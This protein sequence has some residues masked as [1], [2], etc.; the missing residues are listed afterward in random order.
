MKNWSEKIPHKDGWPDI[1]TNRCVLTGNVAKVKVLHRLYRLISDG[2]TPSILDIGCVGPQPLEFW[3]PLLAGNEFSF[4]LTGVDIDGI[5]TAQNIVAQR[6]WTDRVTLRQG[7]GYCLSDLFEPRS[8]NVVIATQVLEHLAQLSLCMQQVAT[9]LT[10]AGEGFFTT[11][12]AHWRS[13]FDLRE[14]VRLVKNVTKKGLGVFGN[15][16]H[17]DLPWFDYEVAAACKQAGLG[18]IE[19]RYYNLSPLKFIHNH[20]VPPER[21][22][23]FMR[24]WF[25]LEEFLNEEAVARE[26]LRHFFLVLYLH[27]RK[28]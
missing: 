2:S 4:H 11:D 17:Y 19:C 20:V 25:E 7:S 26:K 8:F 1:D 21:K 28:L 3:E 6:G 13:R 10:P 9:V 14:P 22:N 24:L 12:S 23:A 18:V 5:E 27:V 15:E 16:R